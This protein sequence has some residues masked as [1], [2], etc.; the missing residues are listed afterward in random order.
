MFLDITITYLFLGALMLLFTFIVS[1]YYLTNINKKNKILYHDFIL[2]TWERTGESPDGNPWF[3]KYFIDKSQ[4]EMKGNPEFYMKA[5][6][7]ILKEDENLIIMELR[8]I[9]GEDAPETGQLAI[10]I[11]KK[12]DMLTINGKTRYFRIA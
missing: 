5:D 1:V 4:I 3:F 6:Y 2:G 12:N 8:N 10:A 7:R 11:D 9:I